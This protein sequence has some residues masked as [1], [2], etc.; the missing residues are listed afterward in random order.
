MMRAEVLNARLALICVKSDNAHG[1]NFA[2]AVAR[3]IIDPL[4]LNYKRVSK[5]AIAYRTR[6][7]ISTD[8]PP[9]VLRVIGRFFSAFEVFL[10]L[11]SFY[12][13]FS[14]PQ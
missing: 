6:F 10:R 7:V 9:R 8:I 4:F 13:T 14:T 11:S 1:V 2:G 3:N 5:N 12:Q